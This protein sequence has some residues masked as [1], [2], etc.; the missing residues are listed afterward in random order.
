MPHLKYLILSEIQ[1]AQIEDE[2][3]SDIVTE[4]LINNHSKRGSKI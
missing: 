1:T 4:E 3:E 2:G